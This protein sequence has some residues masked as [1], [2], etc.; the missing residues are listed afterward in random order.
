MKLDDENW[1]CLTVSRRD[2]DS[3]KFTMEKMPVYHIIDEE[4]KREAS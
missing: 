3:G 2:P 1:H 4:K